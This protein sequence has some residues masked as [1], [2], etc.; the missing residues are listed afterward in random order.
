MEQRFER[1]P[2]LHVRILPLGSPWTD[3]NWLYSTCGGCG[4]SVAGGVQG[5]C[6]SWVGTG[7]VYRLGTTLPTQPVYPRIGIARAQLLTYSGICAHPG[8]PGPF[9]GPSAHLGSPHSKGR[10]SG[11]KSLKLVR[12]AECHHEIRMR[13]GIVPVSKKDPISHDLEFPRIS[14]G[15]AFSPKE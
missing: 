7:W 11:L 1:Y 2:V 14:L 13:P 3:P 4:S 12:T 15:L 8:T 10:D 5:W 6:G 9:L